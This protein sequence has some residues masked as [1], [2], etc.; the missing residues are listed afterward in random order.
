MNR[1]QV[2]LDFHTSEKIKHIGSG[3]SKADF[4][5]A[6]RKG[7]VNSITLFAKCHHGW[8]YYPTE[9][10]QMH[11]ELD[12]DLLGEQIEAAHEIGV[13]TP[14]YIT[15]GWSEHNAQMHP[16]WIARK[17]D[18]SI[19]TSYPL[20]ECTELD[21]PRRN[22]LWINLCPN[23][24]YGTHLR[25]ITEEI[26]TRYPVDGLFYDI[27]FQGDR[28]FCEKCRKD[29]KEQG[30]D[31]ESDQ[32]ASVFFKEVRLKMMHDLNDILHRYHPEGTVFYN[33]SASIYFTLWQPYQTH[34]EMEDMPTAWGGYDKLPMHAKFFFNTGKE[35]IGM[36]GKFHTDW[37]EFGG[38]KTPD[39]LKYEC[40]SML[41]YGAGCSVGDQLHPIGKMD[42]ETYRII[43]EAYNYVEQMEEY[44]HNITPT[45]KLGVMLLDSG[46]STIRSD[47][48]N[49]DSGIAS[50][51]LDS[52]MDFNI[53]DSDSDLTDT[54]VLILPDNIVLAPQTAEKI[55]AFVKRGGGLLISGNSGLDGSGEKFLIDIGLEFIGKSNFE[56]DYVE[57]GSLAEGIVKT[58]FLFYD[59]AN[60]VQVKQGEVL[61]KVYEPY[62]KRTYGSFCSHKNTPYKMEPAVYPAAVQN[63]RILYLA[64]KVCEIYNKNG[65]QYHREYFINALR[66]IYTKPVLEVSMMSKGR[67][68][69]W[70]QVEQKR[71]V[72][73][74]LYASP[75]RRGNTSVI[76]D[77]PDIYNTPV[78]IRT[79]KIVKQ[80]MLM[81]QKE[82]VIFAQMENAIS[83]VVDR[84]RMHQLV[85]IEY[86]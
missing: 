25:E 22:N 80:V 46:A 19:M 33:G 39:A 10:G 76:E 82:K 35:Y 1:R 60:M 59:S 11:P 7:H 36:T 18:G 26:C 63:G 23:T 77:L 62:F 79:D 28:C 13:K 6:L 68:V 15:L 9:K 5:A 47:V 58:P 64:H 69:L 84:F 43:G 12:F 81:P 8:C 61:A 75:I 52:Q 24:E 72:L 29:M 55:N 48:N 78:K 66:R 42:E 71:Y 57:A 32:D 17:K 38:F 54:D 30:L 4:Q 40:A 45:S 44:C 31:P 34:F 73:H 16:E 27:V 3:F 85:V 86:L 83:F 74:L 65:S 37:G 70:E 14:V 50:M 20:D 21:A 56:L 49:S 2:H 53:V 41:A 51:L 67:V